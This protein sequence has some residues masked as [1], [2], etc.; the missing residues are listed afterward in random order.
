MACNPDEGVIKEVND[1]LF[2]KLGIETKSFDEQI[3]ELKGRGYTAI[4]NIGEELEIK[5][6]KFVVNNFVEEHGFMNLK[7]VPKSN[8]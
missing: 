2:K 7:I 4:F 1:D 5:G 8:P 3:N 6:C